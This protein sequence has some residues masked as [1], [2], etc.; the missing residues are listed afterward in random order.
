M[1]LH[2]CQTL[3]LAYKVN[4]IYSMIF[5]RTKDCK[6]NVRKTKLVVFKNGPMLVRNEK[7]MFDG[8][9]LAIVN[10]FS[11]LVLSLSMQLSYNRMVATK[12]QKQSES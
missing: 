7:R 8:Q 3:L 11:C 9:W 1:T 12:L 4:S 10:Y 2:Y 5:V 6:V